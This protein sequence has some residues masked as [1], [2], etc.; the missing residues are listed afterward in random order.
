MPTGY[1]LVEGPPTLEDYR[2]LRADTGLSP[3][4]VE[5]ASAGL[6]GAWAAV[7]VIDD[8]TGE[9]IG[10]GRVLGDGGWYFHVVDMAVLP[11]HQRRGIGAAILTALLDTIRDRAP[12]N[13]YVT[14]MADLPGRPLYTRFGFQ[15]TA[16]G[17]VGMQLV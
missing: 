11:T 14:L 15:E 1:H 9:T 5:Q 6:H 10:M 3:K 7:H 4:T 16:P 17:T 12:A 13:P 8:A 2:R